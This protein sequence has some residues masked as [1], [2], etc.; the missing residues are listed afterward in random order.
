MTIFDPIFGSED[1]RWKGFFDLRGRTTKNPPS[2]I[3]GAEDRRTPHL[4][5]SIFGPEDRRTPHLRSS[6]PKNGSKIGRKTADITQRHI[7]SQVQNSNKPPVA[8]LCGAPPRLTQNGTSTVR[9][10]Q[11]TTVALIRESLWSIE[12]H[13]QKHKRTRLHLNRWMNATS[14][15]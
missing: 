9:F 4:Q 7:I 11:K 1:R 2:S 10:A 12:K 15:S 8:L 6:T 3:F 13:L 14:D 5:S